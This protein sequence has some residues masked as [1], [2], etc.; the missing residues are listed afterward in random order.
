MSDLYSTAIRPDN[1][2]WAGSGRTPG[3]GKPAAPYNTNYDVNVAGNWYAPPMHG[4]PS[5]PPY[6]V[7]N[8]SNT[9]NWITVNKTPILLVAGGLVLAYLVFRKKR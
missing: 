2:S 1:P 3:W 6:A 9:L 8:F 5:Q 7:T 4:A